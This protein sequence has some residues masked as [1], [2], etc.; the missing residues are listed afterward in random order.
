MNSDLQ[1]QGYNCNGCLEGYLR[2]KPFSEVKGYCLDDGRG[3]RMYCVLCSQCSSYQFSKRQE[4]GFFPLLATIMKSQE[5][6]TP[7]FIRYEEER[8]RIQQEQIRIYNQN[9]KSNFNCDKCSKPI[10]ITEEKE[11]CF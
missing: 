8:I 5:I 6:K 3:I 10:R 11:H 2:P 1:A 4:L 7:E 9:F